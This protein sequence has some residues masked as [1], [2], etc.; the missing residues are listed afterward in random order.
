MPSALGIAVPSRHY[1]EGEVRMKRTLILAA[2]LLAGCANIVSGSDRMVVVQAGTIMGGK[3]HSVAEEHCQKYG[4][5]ARV[6][7]RQLGV[8]N[9]TFDCVN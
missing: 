6:A 8:T 2:I 9:W 3:A 4:K 5:H 7:D 1:H